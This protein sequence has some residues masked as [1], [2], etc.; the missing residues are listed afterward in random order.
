MCKICLCRYLKVD[1]FE[2][3]DQARGVVDEDKTVRVYVLELIPK[4]L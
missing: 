2:D 1:R 4:I 3:R